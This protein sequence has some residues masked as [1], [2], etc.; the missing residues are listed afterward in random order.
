MARFPQR[1]PFGHP[2]T[3]EVDQG[4]WGHAPAKA[5]DQRYAKALELL[6]IG[7]PGF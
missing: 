5:T 3:S 2:S 1:W 6:K 7:K 4:G